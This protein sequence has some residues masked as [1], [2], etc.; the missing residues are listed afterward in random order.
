MVTNSAIYLA[1]SKQK[2][3]K[4]ILPHL[5]DGKRKTLL[6][7]FCGT[8][9]VELNCIAQDLFENYYSND[10]EQWVVNLH[11]KL[12]DPVFILDCKAVNEKYPS[13]KKSYLQMRDDY[14]SGGCTDDTLLFNL[15]MRS[16]SNRMRFSG[17]GK[18]YKCNIPY[19]ERNRFDMERMLR[20]H[21]LSQ[22]MEVTQG[23]FASF[24]HSLEGKV[25]WGGVTIYSDS[26]YQTG[27][28]S[29]G[30]VYNT[31]WTDMDD[32]VLLDCIL[33]YQ[34]KGAKIV[35]SNVFFNRGF[36]FNKLIDFCEQHSDKFEVYHLDMDYRNTAHIK[37]E[38]K[39]TDEVLIVSK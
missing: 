31:G 22:K 29:G 33:K 17:R 12:K 34:Q 16:H 23:S 35:L 9:V 26:P 13:D 6:T 32:E 28:K 18:T 11:K 8:G 36:T 25:D 1:G 2:L 5:Q 24:L 15:L 37:Y 14:N 3:I 10:L 21:T 38:G 19:G 7:P 4:D 30:A 39:K 20:H 27:G